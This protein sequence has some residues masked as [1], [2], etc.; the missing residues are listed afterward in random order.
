[1]A[2]EANQTEAGGDESRSFENELAQLEAMV[3]ELETGQLGLGES[4]QRYEQGVTHLKHCYQLLQGA[5]L[6][7]RLLLEVDSTGNE[8]TES[9]SEEAM[10]LDEKAGQRGRRR[11]RRESGPAEGGPS[12]ASEDVDSRRGSFLKCGTAAGPARPPGLAADPP[13][14][15]WSGVTLARWPSDPVETERPNG[16]FR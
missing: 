12:A 4:L 2:K 1:M 9:F 8:R 13:A 7:I 6:R 3:R 10:S 15:D 11:S 16:T 14:N 5:E